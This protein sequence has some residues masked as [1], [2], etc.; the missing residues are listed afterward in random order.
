MKK[1]KIFFVLP[2]LHA[3]G[4]ERVMSFLSENIDETQFYSS[5]IIVGHKKNSKYDVNKIPVHFLNKDRVASSIPTL[6]KILNK[7]RPDIVISSI[8]HINTVMALISFLFP[9][10]KFIGRE[11]NVLSVVKNY[12]NQTNRLGTLIS[13][14]KSYK[15]LDLIVCQSNDM[16]ND[17]NRN[18]K[19]PKSKL[20]V[21][22]NPITDTFKLKNSKNKSNN[23][24][25][26]ITVAALKKQKGHK[27]ILTVLSKLNIPFQ[28]TIIGSGS[29]ETELYRLIDKFGLKNK[30]LHVPF[31]NEVPKYLAESDFFL[32][33][34]FVEG[35]PN[36]LIESCAV[37]TPVLAFAAPGGLDEIIEP[38]LNGLIATDEEEYLK[39]IIRSQNINWNSKD[40]RESVYKKFNSKKILKEY[41]NLFLEMMKK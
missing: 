6:I 1:I 25:R 41:E 4:A 33:G 36:A 5:L 9:K 34:S 14:S 13:P 40:I 24:L 3:G 20:R 23:V 38:E 10:T 31:T 15:F 30:V 27:R 37:G 29:E 16:F 35:F 7:N 22:N 2:T 28:Y 11:A 21:I 39:N 32:Q 17:M 19:I 18:F 12:T 26:F 8:S